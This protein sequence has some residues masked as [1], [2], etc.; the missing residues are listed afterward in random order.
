[1]SDQPSIPGTYSGRSQLEEIV[2]REWVEA[3]TG[4]VHEKEFKCPDWSV[5][6]GEQ[7][8]LVTCKR[9]GCPRCGVNWAR[10]WF[11]VNS[12]NL[13]AY[14]GAIV[15]ATITAPGEGRLPWDEAHC[16]HRRPHQHR[17]P[18]GCRVEQRV[19]REWA[20][21]LTWRWEKLRGAARLATRRDLADPHTG[22]LGPGPTILERAYE[23]QM[24]GVPHLHVV[25]GYRT[26]AE[27][28]AA[29][30][31]VGHLK[32][33]VGQYDFG[34]ADGRGK[35]K[36]L[37]NARAIETRFDVELRPMGGED[38]ARYLSNYLTGRNAKKKTSIRQ[39]IS[40]PIMPRS[41]IWLTPA[42]TS[43]TSGE[44]LQ[45]I[46]I[47]MGIA[48]GTGITM[49]M[50][51]RARHLFAALEGRCIMPRWRDTGDAI[52]TLAVFLQV[53]RKRPPPNDLAPAFA[54][55]KKSDRQVKHYGPW[56]RYAE[57][58]LLELA[59]SLVEM[60]MPAAVAA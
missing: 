3:P 13:R 5:I 27:K 10:D 30:L 16:S 33:L 45:A 58:Q 14:G 22:E 59:T 57:S 32:R 2:Y 7:A 8:R 21:S 38:A 29:H 15:M 46:R 54:F 60:C 37:R 41:L 42:L 39:N 20:E 47:R 17:G 40:D 12:H 36:G 6:P 26:E 28:D 44:R 9:R 23:P 34:F 51:R 4:G 24:R 1:V 11:N 55:A 53:F 56:N 31:F 19:A 49:R 43:S 35:K 50:L 48:H 52:A 25:L 18:A